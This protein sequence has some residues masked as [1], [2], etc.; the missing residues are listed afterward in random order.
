MMVL[1]LG[2][3]GALASLVA[4]VV[5]VRSPELTPS[6]KRLAAA[7]AAPAHELTLTGPGTSTASSS[8][9]L[10]STAVRLG[11]RFGKPATL[12]RLSTKL[13]R[14]GIIGWDAERVMGAK[15]LA[16]GAGA[17]VG[18]LLGSLMGFLP[19]L[20]LVPA[21]AA[22][23]WFIPDLTI[24]QL[25]Y[26]RKQEMQRAAADTIDLLGL[27]MSAGVSMDT[28][29]RTVAA[30]TKGPLSQEIQKAAHATSV[31]MP[32]DEALK[33]MAQRVDDPDVSRFVAAIVQSE[34]RGSSVTEVLSIQSTELRRKQRQAAEEQA[35]KI[36]VKILFPMMVFILPTLGIILMAPAVVNIMFTLGR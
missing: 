29:L 6:Q 2:V 33:A 28:A 9:T 10:T 36:P 22:L 32:R 12:N 34:R 24:Y 3:T 25:R 15:V 35:A 17:L 26:K 19:L 8:S 4:L 21:G 18:V 11:Q 14:A 5:T 27:A 31:G 23:G 1:L 7:T 13:D 30:H 16:A 20:L